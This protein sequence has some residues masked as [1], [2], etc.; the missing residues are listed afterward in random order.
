MSIFNT[1]RYYAHHV[2]GRG[3]SVSFPLLPSF[4]N[5]ITQVIYDADE[6]C[7]D[8]VKNEWNNYDVKI[9]PYCLSE[10][11]AKTNF[12][13]NFCP[14]TSSLYNTNSKYSNYYEEYFIYFYYKI[15][16]FYKNI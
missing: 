7:L 12:N 9:F 4:A 3:G 14:F 6:S 15:C 13:I 10:N 11:N 1:S 16:N 5:E 8:Q 2:G